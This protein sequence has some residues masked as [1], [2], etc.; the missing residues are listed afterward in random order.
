MA[1]HHLAKGRHEG[2]VWEWNPRACGPPGLLG[3]WA[4]LHPD[5]LQSSMQARGAHLPQRNDETARVFLLA[6]KADV[7]I[8]DEHLAG[9]VQL[10]KRRPQGAAR[11]AIQPLV[12]G[13]S[14]CGPV[15]LVLG[16]GIQVSEETKWE[17]GVGQ[18]FLSFTVDFRSLGF[19]SEQVMSGNWN[20]RE[21]VFF[22]FFFV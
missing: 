13:K 9:D 21:V 22:Y 4:S 20:S 6:G 17:A 8:G 15:A 19:S 18:T 12:F 10:V 5:G 3:G 14:E 7:V 16:S 2:Y 1:E 11:V